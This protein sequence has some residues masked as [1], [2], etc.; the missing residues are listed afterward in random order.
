MTRPKC[1]PSLISEKSRRSTSSR[2]QSHPPSISTSTGLTIASCIRRTA[3]GES[4]LPTRKIFRRFGSLTFSSTNWYN[5]T[6]R[7]KQQPIKTHNNNA[8]L[9]LEVDLLG[10]NSELY[11][12]A[13]NGT[14]T[15]WIS[16]F[17]FVTTKC[18]MDF[19]S[20][21]FDEQKCAFVFNSNY[22]SHQVSARIS[23][24]WL[25]VLMASLT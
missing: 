11:F 24:G 6:V 15:V 13:I 3:K 20:F 1:Q 23:G 7:Y 8:I 21:P 12:K 16:L 9:I 19:A 18:K 4:S 14:V 25:P 5:S 2:L 22:P 17:A 10:S